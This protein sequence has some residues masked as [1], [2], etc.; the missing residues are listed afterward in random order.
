MLAETDAAD[1]EEAEIAANATAK[2][3]AM[4]H[5]NPLVHFLAFGLKFLFEPLGFDAERLSCHKIRM[6]TRLKT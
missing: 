4:V 3:A 2:L 6:I 5:A 1:L